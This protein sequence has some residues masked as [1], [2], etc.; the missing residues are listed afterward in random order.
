M[1][2]HISNEMYSYTNWYIIFFDTFSH[3]NGSSSRNSTLL[4]IKRGL[5]DG[6]YSL[7]LR[8]SFFYWRARWKRAYG[9]ELLQITFDSDWQQRPIQGYCHYCSTYVMFNN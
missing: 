6:I 3:H 5:Y 8:V 7:Q 2:V 1:L 9:F 4:I